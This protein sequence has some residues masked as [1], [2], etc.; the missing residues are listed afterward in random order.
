MEAA[1]AGK[2]RQRQRHSAAQLARSS[3]LKL[4]ETSNPQRDR[5]AVFIEMPRSPGCRSETGRQACGI[6]GDGVYE[7]VE[8]EWTG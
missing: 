6:I 8:N 4:N 1:Q 2:Q 3:E 7:K 5:A